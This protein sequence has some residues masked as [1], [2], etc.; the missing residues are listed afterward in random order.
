MGAPYSSSLI[1]ALSGP[2]ADIAEST[3]LFDLGQRE[4]PAVSFGRLLGASVEDLSA[5][6][7]VSARR[8]QFEREIGRRERATAVNM[9]ELPGHEPGFLGT[10]QGDVR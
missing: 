3:R 8:L 4:T 9:Q 1:W 10:Q 6:A 2:F 7:R 5:P